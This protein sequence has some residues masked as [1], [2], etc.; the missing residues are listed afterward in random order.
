MNLVPDLFRNMF[1]VAGLFI[2]C[3]A[4]I[5]GTLMDFN[6]GCGCHQLTLSLLPVR[7]I[8][9]ASIWTA[10]NPFELARGGAVAETIK[11]DALNKDNYYLGASNAVVED[12][13]AEPTETEQT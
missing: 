2:P 13:L 8:P 6:V 4:E 10:E 3:V 5:G 12:R 11:L 1:F 9:A 7:Q